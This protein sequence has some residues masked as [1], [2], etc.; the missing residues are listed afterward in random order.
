VEIGNVISGEIDV[1]AS[2]RLCILKAVVKAN[3]WRIVE[4]K[5]CCGLGD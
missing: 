4:E 3:A 1:E 2:T 5:M